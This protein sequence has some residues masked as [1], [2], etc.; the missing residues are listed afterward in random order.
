MSE[1]YGSPMFGQ[2]ALGLNVI[3]VGGGPANS[4]R[5]SKCIYIYIYIFARGFLKNLPD[6]Y[7]IGFY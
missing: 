5:N 7:C 1:L 3:G 4:M 6:V 2:I